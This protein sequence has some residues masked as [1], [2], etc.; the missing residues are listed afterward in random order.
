MA[1]TYQTK[2]CQTLPV[3]TV[4][5][6]C[7][8]SATVF[9]NKRNYLQLVRDGVSGDKVKTLLQWLP[10]LKPVLV[11]ALSISAANISRLYK[12]TLPSHQAEPVLDMLQLI[13]RAE[14]LFGPDM[15][16]QWLNSP[17]P[18]LSGDK[19]I[20]LFDSFVGR[21]MVADVLQAIEFGEFS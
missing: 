12:G 1:V 4:S 18:A 19:P 8:V 5:D 7:A 3:K 2:P 21:N 16:R 20:A 6:A 13:C 15:A 11:V 10:E 9:A 14:N 17:M